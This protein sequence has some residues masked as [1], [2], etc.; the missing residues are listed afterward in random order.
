[1]GTWVTETKMTTDGKE[2]KQII[3][4]ALI[5]PCPGPCVCYVVEEPG[6]GTH[7]L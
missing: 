4:Q 7:I 5:S 3:K 6:I 1:M 2:V